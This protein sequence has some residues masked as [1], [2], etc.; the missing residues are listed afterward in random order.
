MKY[1]NL[2]I[3]LSFL[4]PFFFIKKENQKKQWGL[5]D[6]SGK[7]STPICHLKQ[8]QIA[9]LDKRNLAC[10]K[11]SES[12]MS[13]VETPRATSYRLRKGSVDKNSR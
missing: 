12:P 2:R 13:L 1:A 3:Y 11:R 7:N 6:C 9:L 8:R 4:S 10:F 5:L